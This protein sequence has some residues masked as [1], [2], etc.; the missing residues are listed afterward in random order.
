M[1]VLQFLK[2]SEADNGLD[3]L[4]IVFSFLKSHN[5]SLEAETHPYPYWNLTSI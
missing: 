1:M 5:N 4:H 3:S 2:V